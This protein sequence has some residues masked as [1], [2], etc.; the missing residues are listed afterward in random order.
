MK[1][2]IERDSD[3]I[4]R[5]LIESLEKKALACT[6]EWDFRKISKDELPRATKYEYAR[7]VKWIRDKIQLWH[8]Q[9]FELQ[10]DCE[11]FKE[12]NG[13]SVGEAIGKIETLPFDVFSAMIQSQ[14]EQFESPPIAD[15]LEISIQ[16]PK[17]FNLLESEFVEPKTGFKILPGLPILSDDR[18]RRIEK[19]GVL[20]LG[21]KIDLRVGKTQLRKDADKELK[22][23]CKK[24]SDIKSL[25]KG[26]AARPWVPLKELAAYRLNES[27]LRGEAANQVLTDYSYDPKHP[28]SRKNWLPLYESASGGWFNAVKN[29]EKRIKEFARTGNLYSAQS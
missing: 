4:K 15:I 8:Q 25:P 18:R 1:I 23:L 19:K 26:A 9:K 6:E 16:F 24:Y 17:P 11:G 7:E 10:E 22:R 20:W 14:P 21:V 28:Q 2:G 12:W 29:A 5:R 27:E 3:Q 13:R